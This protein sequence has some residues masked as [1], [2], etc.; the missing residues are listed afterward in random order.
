VKYAGRE[1]LIR[2]MH[3]DVEE[4]RHLLHAA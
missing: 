2:Q 1:A 3:A 4:A